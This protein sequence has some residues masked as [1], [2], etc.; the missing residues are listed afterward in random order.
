MERKINLDEILIAIFEPVSQDCTTPVQDLQ[1]AVTLNPNVDRIKDAM[2]EACRQ[3]LELAA[4]NAKINWVENNV[5]M[6][7]DTDFSFRDSDGNWC[8]INI[9]EQSILNTIKQIK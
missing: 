7:S 6:E 9:N 4:E 3:T 5:E 1:L 2:K 8:K